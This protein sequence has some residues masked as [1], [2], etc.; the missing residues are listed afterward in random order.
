MG[1][2]L[3]KYSLIPAANLQKV[4]PMGTIN[5]D[6]HRVESSAHRSDQASDSTIQGKWSG[7]RHF[8]NN[9]RPR[10]TVSFGTTKD[11]DPSALSKLITVISLFV[12]KSRSQEMSNLVAMILFIYEVSC[13][14]VEG[15]GSK[16]SSLLRMS[17]NVDK[18]SDSSIDRERACDSVITASRFAPS[19]SMVNEKVLDRSVGS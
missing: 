5:Q 10:S 15:S 13:V 1:L 9:S 7:D 4:R 14:Q 12:S 11:Q 17:S 19:R 16:S 3:D 2:F 6:R 8:D 18:A